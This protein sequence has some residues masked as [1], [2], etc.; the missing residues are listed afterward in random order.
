MSVDFQDQ[1][2]FNP[3][4]DPVTCDNCFKRKILFHIKDGF[5]WCRKCCYSYKTPK[6]IKP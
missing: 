3:L 5:H 2:G 6:E 4:N 1:F